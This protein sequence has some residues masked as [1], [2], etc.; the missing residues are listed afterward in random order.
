V[1]ARPC[2]EGRFGESKAFGSGECKMEIGARREVEQVLTAFVQNFN[3][4]ISLGRAAFGKNFGVDMGGYF[5]SE[6]LC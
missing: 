1:P 4:G 2:G 6:F 5:R 3:F